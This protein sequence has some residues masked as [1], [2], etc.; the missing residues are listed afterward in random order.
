MSQFM[1]QC[2]KHEILNIMTL[3]KNM[4]F[5]MDLTNFSSKEIAISVVVGSLILAN[6]NIF[7]SCALFFMHVT[8]GMFYPAF[9]LFHM[10]N[11]NAN[12]N[13]IDRFTK[14]WIVYAFYNISTYISNILLGGNI[15]FVTFN[16]IFIYL[17]AS[18]NYRIDIAGILYN[19]LVRIVDSNKEKYDQLVVKV[20]E[21]ENIV[22]FSNQNTIKEVEKL[23]IEEVK[24]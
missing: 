7:L 16:I 20:T 17:L 9:K 24:A 4:N 12:K 2:A 18:P 15:F 21:I 23:K 10:I 11:T 13:N 19:Q 22:F 6:L 8:F 1:V 5:G 14:Y 3:A